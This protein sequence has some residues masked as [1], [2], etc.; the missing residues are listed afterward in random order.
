VERESTA[1][2]LRYIVSIISCCPR[3][4]YVDV[5][6]TTV[7]VPVA[8]FWIFCCI[9][10]HASDESVRLFCLDGEFSGLSSRKRIRTI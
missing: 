4:K 2:A 8:I 6:D 9:L 3:D 1:G 10:T 7:P 5:S